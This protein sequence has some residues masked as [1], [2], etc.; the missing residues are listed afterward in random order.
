MDNPEQWNLGSGALT[1]GVAGTGVVVRAGKQPLAACP[2]SAGTVPSDRRISISGNHPSHHRQL[3]WSRHSVFFFF[4]S[5]FSFPL[6]VLFLRVGIT[7]LH[8]TVLQN[9]LHSV[10]GPTYFSIGA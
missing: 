4:F 5:L 9:K 8:Y 2:I 1:V 6:C 7:P 10:T 3:A